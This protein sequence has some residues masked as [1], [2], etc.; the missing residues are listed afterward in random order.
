[1]ATYTNIIGPEMQARVLSVMRIMIGLT[2]LQSGT[3]KHLGFPA[4]PSLTNVATGSLPWWG[5]F[6]ELIC[7]TLIVLGLFTRP[8]AFLAC[9]E[10][11]VAYFVAHAPRGFF[12]AANGGSL[13]VAYCFAFL[14]LAFAGGGAWSLDR[15]LAGRGW[16]YW[17]MR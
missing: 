16:R 15:L 9:G 4:V 1:M 8:A 5:G 10:V 17:W 2:Y 14:Y 13:A 6:V 12:P 3:G 7:G 11:A